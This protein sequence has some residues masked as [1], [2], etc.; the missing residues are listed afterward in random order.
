MLNF[1]LRAERKFPRENLL[2][3][4]NTIDAHARALFEPGAEKIIVIKEIVLP[5]CP[6]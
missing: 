6:G 4:K 3:C 5:V 1:S 2:R